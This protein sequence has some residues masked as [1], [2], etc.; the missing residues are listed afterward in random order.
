[1]NRT[2]PWRAG[3]LDTMPTSILLTTGTSAPQINTFTTSAGSS[4]SNPLPIPVVAINN[5]C[6]LPDDS[7]SITLS[8]TTSNLVDDDN[9][10]LSISNNIGTLPGNVYSS[11]DTLYYDLLADT[12]F[13]MNAVNINGAPSKSLPVY[14]AA[15]Q[16]AVA[17]TNFTATSTGTNSVQLTWTISPGV[18]ALWL[19]AFTSNVNVADLGNINSFDPG[20][21]TNLS[22]LAAM[23][24]TSLTVNGVTETTQY[25]LFAQ[26]IVGPYVWFP[27]GNTPN[28][29]LVIES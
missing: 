15:K 23:N 8:W 5:S 7:N 28:S 24:Q 29:S 20:T 12:T 2:R 10:S 1:M 3:Q 4:S 16:P 9:S 13:T 19:G 22:R 6:N 26:D 14:V 11:G 18:A 21:Y 17:I 27:N 25:V